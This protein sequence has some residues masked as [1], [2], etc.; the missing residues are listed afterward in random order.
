MFHKFS[1]GMYERSANRVYTATQRTLESLC[2][3][4]LNMNKVSINSKP[5]DVVGPKHKEG[6]KGNLTKVQTIFS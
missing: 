4:T 2:S 5:Y 3:L 1:S 6:F